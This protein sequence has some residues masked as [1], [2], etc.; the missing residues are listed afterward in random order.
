MAGHSERHG[1]GVPKELDRYLVPS[2]QVVF[3]LRRHW[4]V[5]AE[6]FLTTLLGLIVLATISSQVGDSVETAFT[7]LWLLLLSRLIIVA[8]EWW[9]ELVVATD[10]R[11]M[12]VH[13]VITRKVDIMPMSKVTDMRYDRTVTGQILGYGKFVMESAGQDQALGTINYIPD[14][15]LHYQQISQLIFAPGEP[16]L[17]QRSGGGSSRVPVS[18]PEQAW[19]RRK[20]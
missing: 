19:W 13:G 17:V 1:P 9:L 6:P 8:W 20:A 11:L 18:E 15:D 5:L 2:E 4:V 3:L 16:R 12:L 7:L 10:K 14:S